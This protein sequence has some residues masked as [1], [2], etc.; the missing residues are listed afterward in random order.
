MMDLMPGRSGVACSKGR[1]EQSP[2][3]IHFE[4]E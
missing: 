2:M 3:C 4:R 1:L